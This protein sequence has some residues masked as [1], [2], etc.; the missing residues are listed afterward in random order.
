MKIIFP[1]LI[2]LE[3]LLAQ[4]QAVQPRLKDVFKNNFLIGAALN[5]SQFC[6]SNLPIATLVKAQFNT[7]TPENVLKWERVHP[8]LGR[9]DFTMADKYVAFGESHHMV[10]IGHTLVWHNQTPD[11]VFQDATGQ[12]LG[13]AALLERMRE[14]IF[15]VVG[16]YQGRIKGWD[17]ANEAIAEDGSPRATLWRKIIGEDYLLLA[18]QFAHAA[19]PAAELYYNDYGLENRQK[20]AGALEL[21][22]KLQAAGVPIAGVGLQ[23]HYKLAA[24]IP[25]AQ[26]VN[27]AIADF[28]RLGVKVMITELDVDVLPSAQNSLSAEIT[29]NFKAENRL[30]PFPHQLPASLQKK[31]AARYAEL[32]T[33]FCQNS[34]TV[35]RVTMWGVTDAD[36][37]L[38]DW[39]IA[40][41]TSYPLLF[42][43]AGQPKLAFR[44][45]VG[46][47]ATNRIAAPASS[48]LKNLPGEKQ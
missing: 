16:R 45:V 20:R 6:E 32:F 30:N 40:G 47:A 3:I 19:D 7:I 28:A 43:R 35:T 25:T 12:P 23:G 22:K 33:I 44:Q 21:V 8:E 48:S 46:V 17:V 13:R 9:Y 34:G 38:N 31:L 10:I 42:D 2:A 37:W 39:P 41:R 14:H 27:E 4:S 24:N 18:Y 26:A 5:P 15:S 29:T 1:I 11:W 36:S